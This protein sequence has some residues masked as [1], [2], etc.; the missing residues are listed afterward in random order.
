M[1]ER[2]ISLVRQEKVSLFI[3]AGF[4]LEANAPS[5]RMLCEAILSQFDNDQQRK[6]H[7]KDP[8]ADLANYFVEEICCGSRNSLIEMLQEQFSFTPAKMD[9]HKALAKIPH[10]H[11]IFTTNYDTL[12]E[13]SYDKKECQVIRKDADCAYIDNAKPVHVFK[14][15]GDF[16]AG[17]CGHFIPKG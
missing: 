2:I 3:G 16:I 13:D 6:E 9:D 14:I 4:S 11:N 1:F 12:L 10:F 8:L 5:V 17:K 15:H 7:E